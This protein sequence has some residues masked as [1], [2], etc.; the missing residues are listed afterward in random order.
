MES[1]SLAACAQAGQDR[2]RRLAG[3]DQSSNGHQVVTGNRR[4][5]VR[6]ISGSGLPCRRARPQMRAANAS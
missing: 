4:F 3:P 6:K 1:G 2:R 5:V